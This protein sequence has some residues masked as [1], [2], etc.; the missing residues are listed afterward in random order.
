MMSPFF[1]YCF[2]IRIF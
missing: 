1:R 2:G